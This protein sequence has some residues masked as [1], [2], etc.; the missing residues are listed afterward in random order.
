MA[1]ESITPAARFYRLHREEQLARK[2]EEYNNRPDIIAKR[3]ERERNKLEKE[4]KKKEKQDAEK[5]AKQI[6]KNKKIQERIMIAEKTKR[7]IKKL[8]EVTLDPF[9]AQSSPAL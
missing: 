6:E 2:K 8:S 4:M 5:L 9:L 1:E 7:K 3:E